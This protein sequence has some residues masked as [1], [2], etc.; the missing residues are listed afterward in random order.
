MVNMPLVTFGL[1]ALAMFAA[2]AILIFVL[3]GLAIVRQCRIAT[4]ENRER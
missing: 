1:F 3:I 4:L 2:G